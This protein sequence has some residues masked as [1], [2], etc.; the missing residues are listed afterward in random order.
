VSCSSDAPNGLLV[1]VVTPLAAA[2]AAAASDAA[3]I[4]GSLCIFRSLA[5]PGPQGLFINAKGC[6]HAQVICGASRHYSKPLPPEMTLLFLTSTV[7]WSS[8]ATHG[9]QHRH[10]ALAA[11]VSRQGPCCCQQYALVSQP[12]HTFCPASSPHSRAPTRMRPGSCGSTL[13]LSAL[14]L[15]PAST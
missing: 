10:Q 7:L 3:C 15:R 4:A 1:K 8:C 2:V 11:A 9:A 13:T 14:R 12:V 6:M 5:A